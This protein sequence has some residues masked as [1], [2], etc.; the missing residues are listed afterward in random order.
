MVPIAIVLDPK[1]KLGHITHGEHKFVMKTSL[2]LLEYVRIIENLSTVP[3]DDLMAS[4][5]H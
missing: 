3:I 1:F 4:T 2:N 5:S